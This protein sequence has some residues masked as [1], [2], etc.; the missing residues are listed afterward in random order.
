VEEY[1]NLDLEEYAISL[2]ENIDN[3][4]FFIPRLCNPSHSKFLEIPHLY[5]I[6]YDSYQCILCG[7]YHPGIM[8]MGQLLEV[9]IKEII[10]VHDNEKLDETFTHLIRYSEDT[11]RKFRKCSSTPLLPKAI[12]IFLKRVNEDIRNPYMH[13][14]Y[15]TL[16]KN[17]K[18]KSV[19]YNVGETLEEINQKTAMILSK[20]HRSEIP[21]IE[22]NPAINNSI[23][24]KTKRD[25]EFNWAMNWAWEIYPFF[26]LLIEGYLNHEDYQKHADK[27]RNEVNEIPSIDEKI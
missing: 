16:F 21:Y 17:D 1:I 18:I 25:N 2:K 24:D 10:F 11:T 20:I 9:T 5:S 15:L 7:L 26:E 4:E 13:L 19:K 6:Y 8:L 12:I 3:N 14:N 22:I 27:Y 23:A